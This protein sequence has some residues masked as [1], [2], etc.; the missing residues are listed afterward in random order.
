MSNERELGR[1]LDRWFGDGP[2]QAPDRILIV[3]ADRIERQPQR[4]V[5]RLPKESHVN[6]YL[7]PLLAVVAVLAIALIGY[8]LLP[9]TG[10]NVGG[11]GTTPL[12]T[13]TRPSG[14]SPSPSADAITCE[15]DA[16]DCLGPLAAGP[17]TTTNFRPA[18]SFTTTL[19]WENNLD[20]A[21]WYYLWPNPAMAGSAPEILIWSNVRIAHQQADCIPSPEPDLGQGAETWMNWITAH[22]GL[23]ATNRAQ[24]V[25]GGFAGESIDLDVAADW[26]MT[27]P[28]NPGAGADPYVMLIVNKPG[29][30]E[31]D[32]GV[33]AHQR[34]HLEF[35]DVPDATDVRGGTT[36]VIAIYS[37]DS[38]EALAAAVDAVR[39]IIDSIQFSQ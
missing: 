19:G 39:P 20:Q 7:K 25:I 11:P 14:S 2:T 4:H 17:H 13:P 6:A 28:G 9:D 26:T 1:V 22:P 29:T 18:F 27:C 38:A 35:V 32:Y 21:N 15:F 5:W 30:P 3:V 16:R 31:V 12:P 23:V 8:N 36:V 34:L 10:P 24:V 37:A 33:P